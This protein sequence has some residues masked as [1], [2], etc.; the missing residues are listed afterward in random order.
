MGLEL[1]AAIVEVLERDRPHP[2]AVLL[3]LERRREQRNQPPPVTTV[4]T[5]A[6]QG[7]ARKPHRLDTYDQLERLSD[8]E[9]EGDD[10]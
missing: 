6:G 3:V 5:C 9:A 8:D 7:R 1:Q 4:G 10:Q 2:N